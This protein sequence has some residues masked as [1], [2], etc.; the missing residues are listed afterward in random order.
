MSRRCGVAQPICAGGPGMTEY[1]AVVVEQATP[2]STIGNPEGLHEMIG[3]F[4]KSY[5]SSAS[6]SGVW[7]EACHCDEDTAELR[8]DLG[9]TL[10]ESVE[11]ELV[12]GGRAGR[13]RPF[14]PHQAALAA[15][16]LTGMVDRFCYVTYVFDPPAEGPTDPQEATDLLTSLWAGAIH[17]RSAVDEV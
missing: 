2:W 14:T 9:R 3:S 17:L 4:V 10:T 8:R 6:L 13:C 16:A 12:R 15:R 11:R 1:V 5:A 7:E